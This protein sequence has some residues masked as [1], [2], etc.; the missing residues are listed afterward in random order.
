VLVPQRIGLQK[1]FSVSA[2]PVPRST[3]EV[4]GP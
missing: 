1:Q 3:E 4:L 2:G